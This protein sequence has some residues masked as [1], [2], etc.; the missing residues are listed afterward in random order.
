MNAL[1]RRKLAGLTAGVADVKALITAFETR[2]GAQMGDLAVFNKGAQAYA[3][4]LTLNADGVTQMLQQDF[5]R[6]KHA[7]EVWKQRQSRT[8]SS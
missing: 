7:M 4:M 8:I 6:V 3:E 1:V 5:A 2:H